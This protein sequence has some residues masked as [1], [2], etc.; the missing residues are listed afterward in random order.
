MR[1]RSRHG[2][3]KDNLEQHSQV[4]DHVEIHHGHQAGDQPNTEAGPFGEQGQGHDWV[5]G[6]SEL[7]I[8]ECREEHQRDEEG[9]TGECLVG[10]C[11]DRRGC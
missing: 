9:D 11:I 1:T 3:L 4:V 7:D 8:G 5:P 2:L 10:S 6:N